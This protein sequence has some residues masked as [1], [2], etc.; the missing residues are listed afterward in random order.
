MLVAVLEVYSLSRQ[1]K[2]G[3]FDQ[4][5]LRF[6]VSFRSDSDAYWCIKMCALSRYLL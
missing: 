3:A 6:L 2:A 1:V 5:L 4:V